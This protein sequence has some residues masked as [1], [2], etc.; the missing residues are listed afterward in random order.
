MPV[1]LVDCNN[2]YA[3][4]ERV[5]VPRLRDK[6]VAVLSNNDGCIIARSDEVK[7]LNIPMGAPYFK[8]RETLDAV[9]AHIFSANF[10]LYGD[11]SRRVMHTLE[12]FCN[13]M[14]VYSIDEAFLHVP[15]QSD[16][17]QLGEAIHQRVARWTGIPVRVGIGATK[18]L[19]KAASELAKKTKK[20]TFVLDE[21][22]RTALAQVKVEDVWGI[23]RRWGARLRRN[24]ITTALHLCGL[25]DQQARRYMNVIGLRTVYE[26]RG[27]PCF[28]LEAQPP[29]RKSVVHSRSFGEAVSDP[30]TMREVLTTFV[31]RAAMKLRR[32][33]LAAHMLHVFLLTGH[34]H[35][36]DARQ[37]A[38]TIHLSQATNYTPWLL[39]AANAGLHKAWRP[40][41]SYTKA[42]VLCYGLVP[43]SPTQ[44]HLFFPTDP[45]HAA[46]M[47]TLDT[48][49]RKAGH[50]AVV[51]AAA[52]PQKKPPAWAT[53]CT[54]RSPRYTTRWEELPTA[55]A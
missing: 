26:L 30:A 49:N 54:L 23:G 27:T 36:P 24:H 44:G 15:A 1:V 33:K 20:R 32:D 50:D 12:T 16:L 14:E 18:T 38:A 43:E 29:T 3:S 51:F 4:C 25:S 13:Q 21:R 42:G 40:N 35:K 9:G 19:A 39:Q 2:F 7:A 22:N 48:I 46:L 31:S 45:R 28:P 34:R 11:L 47:H 55:Y 41:S 53:R 10:E 5:F 52:R 8:H 37:D 17:T 6:P